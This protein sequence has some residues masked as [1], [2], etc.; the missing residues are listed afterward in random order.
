M[1]IQALPSD[2]FGMADVGARSDGNELI[3]MCSGKRA[4]MTG[5]RTD[6]SSIDPVL[7][8]VWFPSQELSYLIKA[9]Q[10]TRDPAYGGHR[11][12]ARRP[13]ALL[14]ALLLAMSMPTATTPDEFWSAYASSEPVLAGQVVTDPFAGGGSTLVE[15]SRLGADVIGSDIDPLA[16]RVSRS[17]LLPPEASEL[18]DAG[19]AM[20][21]D[22]RKRLG[23]LYP[24]SP[25]ETPLHYFSFA[26]VKCLSCS[27]QSLLYR[28]PQLALD[29]QLRGA[30]VREE[31][32]TVVCPDCLHLQYLPDADAK[33]FDCCGSTKPIDSGTYTGTSFTCPECGSA[34]THRQLQTGQAPRRI[35]AVEV[36]RA[37]RRRRLREPTKEDVAIVD[38]ALEMWQVERDALPR[39]VGDI[40]RPRHDERPMSYGIRTYE[41]L[42]TPR[43][44]LVLGHAFKWVQAQP[45]SADLLSSL[46]LAISNSLTTNNR[47]CGYARD[48][49]RLSAL[50]SIRGYSLPSM[51]IELNPLHP[52]GGRGTL[53][54]CI[55]RMAR[56]AARRVRRYTWS[57]RNREVEPIDLTFEPTGRVVVAQHNAMEQ[58]PGEAVSWA[59]LAV[60]DPPYFNFIAYE[61]L[62]QFHRVWLGAPN[63]M[64][65]P[66]LPQPGDPVTSFAEGLA[67]A[68][69][70]VL[71]RLK[72]G[73][74]LAFTYHSAD[75]NAWKAIG[76]ALDK[77]QLRV[78]AIWPV[79]S[80]AHMGHHSHPGNCEWDLVLI[81]RPMRD[82][83]P[84]ELSATV[85]SWVSL[86]APLEIEEADRLTVR[87]ADRQNFSCAISVAGKRYGIV[88]QGQR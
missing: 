50:F 61:E 55:E 83:L 15:A 17:A 81:C 21:A 65:A 79:R 56:S 16:V 59:D 30:V 78:T 76:L 49:G 24:Q 63:L 37:G 26:E 68:F 82:T 12:W 29:R 6:G 36:T 84:T 52:D 45:F 28:D 73:K 43:Q 70:G 9:D 13:P 40:V 88:A 4:S 87:E 34:A 7:A 32:L 1:P 33:S 53:E 38:L 3:P 27:A 60:F 42:F 72:S 14:R 19:E 18:R 54:A 44:L 67:K 74:P 47:L 86:V 51:A 41:Q 10:R 2:T 85:S 71:R 22:L 20:I 5:H 64:G 77:A 48:Y 31:A 58:A 69:E 57:S 66:L 80:D 62:S 25:G 39:P 8:E 75:P 46:E 11:W 23:H 35:V